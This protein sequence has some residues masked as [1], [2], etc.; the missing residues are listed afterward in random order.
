MNAAVLYLSRNL[1]MRRVVEYYGYLCSISLL[2][3]LISYLF[4]VV[5][6]AG[7]R[8]YIL[9]VEMNATQR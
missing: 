8:E 9:R 4:L 5:V 3:G 6:I 2:Y 7:I 1:S